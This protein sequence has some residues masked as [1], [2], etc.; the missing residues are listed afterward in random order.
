MPKKKRADGGWGRGQTRE[1][2]E[3][4]GRKQVSVWLGPEVRDLLELLAHSSDR[5]KV[6]SDLILAASGA[7]AVKTP[8]ITTKSRNHVVSRFHEL[9]Q[10][11]E[12]GKRGAA[13]KVGYGTPWEA[14]EAAEAL[15]ASEA[16]AV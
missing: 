13:A 5:T 15:E 6:I 4:K 14:L 10:F 9:W 7:Y 16:K 8:Q 3:A 11:V 1:A 12:A 2:R